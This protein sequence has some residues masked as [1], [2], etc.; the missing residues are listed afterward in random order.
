[1]SLI[2]SLSGRLAASALLAL[3]ATSL[4]VAQTPITVFEDTFGAGSTF[5]S[6]PTSP[7]DASANA[8]AYQIIS[9][10]AYPTGTPSIAAPVS[11]Q[12]GSLR[13]ALDSSVSTANVT[14]QA[15][16]NKYPVKLVN[17]GDYIQLTVTFTAET[18]LLT[19]S[20]NTAGANANVLYF[21]L[22]GSSGSVSNAAF[23]R[24]TVVTPETT[25]PTSFPLTAYLHEPNPAR[26]GG[27]TNSSSNIGNNYSAYWRGYTGR[28]A[29]TGGRHQVWVQNSSG[30]ANSGN[31]SAVNPIVN[32]T[33]A[34]LSVG[35]QYTAVLRITRDNTT[36][37]TN[38]V[39]TTST[40]LFIKEDLYLGNVAQGTPLASWTSGGVSG[41]QHM[42]VVYDSLA[43]GFKVNAN[44]TDGFSQIMAI[45]S[46]TVATTG[47]TVIAPDILTQ[48]ASQNV[49]FGDPV[50]FTVVATGGG[51]PSASLS[52]QWRKDGLDIDGATAA[53]YTI[54]S[55]EF[56]HA[57]AYSVVVTNTLTATSTVIG[58]VTSDNA[59]L[60]VAP[61]APPTIATNPSDVSTVAGNS[62]SFTVVPIGSGLSY[63]WEKSTDSGATW[64][65]VAGANAA[66]Y[67]IART[68]SSS[69]GQ[70]RAVVTNSTASVTSAPASLTLSF[71]TVGFTPSGYGSSATGGGAVTAVTVST[72]AD[73]KAQ[74]EA[75]GPAVI[76]VAG[77]LTLPAKVSV[78]SE[79]TIQGIDGEATIIGNLELASGV[80]NVVIRGLNITNPA[81]R[82]L[83]VIGATNV[84]INHVSF[85]DCSDTML[86]LTAGADNVTVSWCE[87]YFTNPV[88]TNKA[89]LVG[90]E[91]ETKPISVTFDHNWWADY[92]ASQMPETTYGR[93]HMY[94]NLFANAAGTDMNIPYTTGV[95][96]GT[97]V[98]A[99]AQLFSERNQYTRVRSPLAK[100]AAAIGLI[101]AAGNV[102]TIP[103]G[104]A[105]HAGLDYLS[106]APPYSYQ[107]A[108]T[109][110]VTA[111]VMAAAG[112]VIGAA[113]ATPTPIGTASITSTASTVPLGGSFTLT[114]VTTDL[115]LATVTP[116]QWRVNGTP[117]GAASATGTLT[118][119]GA[120]GS[121]TGQFTVAVL[122]A[123][124]DTIVSTPLTVTATSGSSLVPS[125]ESEAA[126]GGGAP[127]A[128]FFGALALLAT[129]RRFLLPR[130]AA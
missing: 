102:Y 58:S 35:Q 12:P 4:A 99:N 45:N 57:G 85:F 127:S 105:P 50:T 36:S 19:D 111:D 83:T 101:R 5:N 118:V 47:A 31:T 129:L 54:P 76:T 96:T 14:A 103:S 34:A 93:L 82:G 113:T 39:T 92:T 109:T 29:R 21:G 124:G 107:L 128:W 44:T 121:N 55:T 49:S 130:K 80:S 3:T 74:A 116:Y 23:N 95:T 72:A 15:I 71:T 52:Y 120:T 33:L 89:T 42:G 75:T 62:A 114:A 26:A 100:E 48:P 24:D 67:T 126:G 73:F 90:A 11:G 27:M 10:Q 119:D 8:T 6:N 115:T 98:R 7:A 117:I 78:K 66:T 13:I 94:N 25:P 40:R 63:Q 65:P 88:E 51:D 79:K 56:S 18:A 86:S 81:G 77:T 2:R 122:L 84:Y 64:S 106:F 61:P 53:S 68:Q 17:V 104:T 60:F 108:P 28:L 22:Y 123:N 70:Y 69:I 30:T 41:S 16:F 46:V 87:F 1:M 20:A 37:T 59:I 112:N 97:R 125:S 91:G 9:G 43:V 38:G 32:S 110:S